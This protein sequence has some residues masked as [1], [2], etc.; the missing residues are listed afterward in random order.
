MN[1]VPSVSSAYGISVP[2]QAARHTSTGG[3]AADSEIRAL[4]TGR[5]HFEI[6]TFDAYIYI[7][8]PRRSP[9]SRHFKNSPRAGATVIIIAVTRSQ[10][11]FSASLQSDIRLDAR[12]Y[13][14]I[15]ACGTLL[16]PLIQMTM[17]RTAKR[18]R[19]CDGYH[20]RM[21]SY[22]T[23]AILPSTGRLADAPDDVLPAGHHF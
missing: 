20:F 19:P 15:G 5:S 11:T 6:D 7:T 3:R 17:T 14:K 18:R 2:L 8:T 9:E 12:Q 21:L 23:P 22:A 13:R 4:V 1:V 10:V 16:L